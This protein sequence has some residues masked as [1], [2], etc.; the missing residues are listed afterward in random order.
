MLFSYI[1]NMQEEVHRFAI[2]YHRNLRSK[3]MVASELDEIPGIGPAKRTALL[4]EFGSVD[5]IKEADIDELTKVKGISR[6][7]AE[8][9]LKYF[10]G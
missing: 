2:D 9:I 10:R 8:N 3:K 7:N 5:K 1:G 6:S 4:T